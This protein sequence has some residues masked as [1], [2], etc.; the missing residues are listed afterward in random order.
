LKLG[1]HLDSPAEQA[2][3]LGRRLTFPRE[4][5][6]FFYDGDRPLGAEEFD[7][8]FRQGL[9]TIAR[10]RARPAPPNW[11]GSTQP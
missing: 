3:V 5:S 8:P 1:G 7:D 10:S 4:P 2:M 9:L 11:P 6:S